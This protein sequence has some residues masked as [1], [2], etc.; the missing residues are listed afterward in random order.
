MLAKLLPRNE[1]VMDRAL[2][3]T[4]GIVILSLYFIGPQTPWGL[5]GLIPITTGLLGSCPVYTIF[6]ISTC[7]MKT[8]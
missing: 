6:G 4:F 1:S 7:R 3:V 2:R 5:L 8:G